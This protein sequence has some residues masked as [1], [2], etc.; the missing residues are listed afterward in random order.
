MINVADNFLYKGAKPLDARIQYNSVADMKAVA[1]ADL[2]DG[3]KAYVK[4][5]KKFYTFDSSNTVDANLGKWREENAGGGSSELSELDDVEITEPSDGDVLVYDAETGKWINGE[6][7]DTDISD[8]GDVDISNPQNG[9]IL[10]YNSTTGKWENADIIVNGYGYVQPMTTIMDYINCIN[11]LSD[12]DK[13][14]TV[15]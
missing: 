1:E 2:Y 3:C 12:S 13:Q 4:A 7:K 15:F 5:T 6:G 11:T 9:Q 8:L 14:I 10:Q